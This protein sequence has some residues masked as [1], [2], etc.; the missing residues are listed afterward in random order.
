MHG[1]LTI[2]GVVVFVAQPFGPATA[3]LAN[4]F[5]YVADVDTVVKTAIAAG[6]TVV[7]PVGDMAN[8]SG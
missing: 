1:H 2:E 5:L 6:A 3:T 8:A 4:L 7:A